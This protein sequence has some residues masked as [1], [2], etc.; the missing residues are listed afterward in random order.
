MAGYLD[1]G[2]VVAI[3]EAKMK[4]RNSKIEGMVGMSRRKLRSDLEE[5]TV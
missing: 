5:R 4:K 3:R 2:R 1:S